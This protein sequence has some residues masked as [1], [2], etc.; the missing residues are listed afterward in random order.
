[1]YILPDIQEKAVEAISAIFLMALSQG[2]LTS[3]FFDYLSIIEDK[4]FCIKNP[5]YF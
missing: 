5:M 3:G 1:M 2:Y 4:C